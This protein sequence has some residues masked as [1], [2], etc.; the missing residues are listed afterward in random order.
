MPSFLFP[1]I[2]IIALLVTKP[3]R[4]ISVALALLQHTHHYGFYYFL[5]I[6]VFSKIIKI[7]KVGVPIFLVFRIEFEKHSFSP[8]QYWGAETVMSSHGRGA[9]I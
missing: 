5:P 3:K 7:A 9:S 1:S 4:V 8:D 2:E 6:A